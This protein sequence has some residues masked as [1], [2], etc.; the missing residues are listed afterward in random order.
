[1]KQ[2]PGFMMRHVVTVEP[3]VG[4]N[5]VGEVY[6]V[7]VDIK[8]MFVEKRKMVRNA[9]GEEV[10]SSCSYITLPEH[11]PPLNSRVT[12]KH[13][14]DVRHVV[15]LDVNTW[16]GMSVPANSQAYLD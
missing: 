11:R 6:G 8:C 4:T 5:A 15:S 14:G 13:T 2:I 9:Q 10:S 16:P 1:M 12:V 7:G 3:Y